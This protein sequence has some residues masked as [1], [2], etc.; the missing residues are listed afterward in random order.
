MADTDESSKSWPVWAFLTPLLMLQLPSG[1]STRTNP[2]QRVAVPPGRAGPLLGKAEGFGAP[3][4]GGNHED[5]PPSFTPTPNPSV[6]SPWVR[7]C[8][9]SCSPPG[10]VFPWDKE[11]PLQNGAK[12]GSPVVP[13]AVAGHGMAKARLLSAL[14]PSDT[15]GWHRLEPETA[16]SR[17]DEQTRTHRATPHKVL[18]L[19]QAGCQR[20]KK[21][22]GRM[23]FPPLH[24]SCLLS[25]LVPGDP[26]PCGQGCASTSSPRGHG[27]GGKWRKAHGLC[28]ISPA[29][30]ARGMR[31][32]G[33]EMSGDA[34]SPTNGPFNQ[35][36]SCA[37]RLRCPSKS[38]RSSAPTRRVR[39]RHASIAGQGWPHLMEAVPSRCPGP[40]PLSALWDTTPA[41]CGSLE[42]RSGTGRSPDSRDVF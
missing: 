4:P 21:K 20:G 40:V 19:G 9:Q 36:H 8:D 2:A 39:M 3:C 28:P 10:S 22:E 30:P 26:G 5:E 23:P 42:T 16:G 6:A 14:H 17:G 13:R 1:T 27:L 35:Q 24:S 32:E 38:P 11:S 29:I 15:R 37:Q 12:T 41:S 18:F 25:C 31:V 7:R 34:R 33:Q